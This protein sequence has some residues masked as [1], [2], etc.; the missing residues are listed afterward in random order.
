LK[1]AVQYSKPWNPVNTIARTIVKIK[2]QTASVFKPAVIAWWA[3]VTVAPE[4]RSI[5]VLTKGTS[6]GLK[7]LIPFGGHIFP[8]SIVGAI[9]AA[10]K[11]PEKGEKKT[12]PQ[13]Q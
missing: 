2:P 1:S 4:H 7:V 6:N 12:L 5:K 9:L 10:K 11:G 3:Y 8:I 13:R